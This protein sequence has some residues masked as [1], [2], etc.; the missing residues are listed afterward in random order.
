MDSVGSS[1]PEKEGQ[2]GNEPKGSNFY[3]LFF[4]GKERKNSGTVLAFFSSKSG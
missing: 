2:G 3:L 4:P 1:S